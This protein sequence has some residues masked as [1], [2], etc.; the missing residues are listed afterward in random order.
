M[1]TRNYVPRAN[2]E[3]SI[4]TEKKHWS[5]GFFDKL[6]VR[7]LEVIG[8]GAENDAQPA[9]VGWVKQNVTRLLKSALEATG[10][11]I[12]I[13]HSKAGYI[14][15][16]ELLGGLI[17]Q[18][19]EGDWKNG[20]KYKEIVYPISFKRSSILIPIDEFIGEDVP[21]QNEIGFFV[22][23]HNQTTNEKFRVHSYAQGIGAF[24]YLAI[25]F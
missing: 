12:N 20:E 22:V 11:R 18:W 17:V 8:G 4:G 24:T 25:G 6:A 16:G 7:T 13:G 15:F 3:G 14:C 19:G 9:T 5:A 10:M 23:D 21:P 1:A 2:G